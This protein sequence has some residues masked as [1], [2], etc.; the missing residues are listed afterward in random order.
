[1]TAKT[2]QIIR[3][4]VDIDF[5]IATPDNWYVTREDAEAFHNAI[6]FFFPTGERFF[7][8][9][10]RHYQDRISDP[11][12][13]E[14]VKSFIYQEAMHAKEHAR[15]NHV[16]KRAHRYGHRIERV[17]QTM[18]MLAR[19]FSPKG[20]QLGVTCAIEHFTAILSDSLLRNQA[21]FLAGAHPAFAQLWIWHAVEETE[22]KAVCFDV[23][24]HVLGNGWYSYLNRVVAMFVTTGFFL[25]AIVVGVRLIK[26]GR[27]TKTDGPNADHSNN[28]PNDAQPASP[29]PQKTRN[30]WTLL[31]RAVPRPLS[32]TLGLYVDY[33][34]WSFHPWNHDNADLIEEWKQRFPDFGTPCGTGDA[35]RQ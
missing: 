30:L 35:A 10:V 12:L 3:R 20:F 23:H 11:V 31:G 5:D 27:K 16:L 34:R 4:R 1:M 15:C 8:E 17:S 2:T 33:Y 21:Q 26:K 32:R 24:Q 28:L 29:R 19:R 25:V 7:I 22:H 13:V 9:S 18:L 6:S 14:Q